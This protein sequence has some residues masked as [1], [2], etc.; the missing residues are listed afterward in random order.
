MCNWDYQG[1]IV[2]LGDLWSF[3]ASEGTEK[4]T[5]LWFAR[6]DQYP[7]WCYGYK[8]KGNM[9]I[10]MYKE[11]YI[12]LECNILYKLKLKDFTNIWSKN[13]I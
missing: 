3:P 5:G 4:I 8:V 11:N 12:Q 6:E 2:C 10:N 9:K 13:V 7:G 1:L